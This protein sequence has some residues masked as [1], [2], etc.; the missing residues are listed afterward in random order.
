MA[1][2]LL[3][4]YM[5]CIGI[6][7]IEIAR[8]ETAI[9]RWGGHFLKHVYTQRELGLCRNRTPHLAAQFAAKEAVMKALGTGSPHIGW[10]EIEILSSSNGKPQ[11]HLGG[12]AEIKAQELGLEEIVI[13]LSH[14]RDYAIASV[15]GFATTPSEAE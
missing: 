8:I 3:N 12:R 11:V 14:S 10:Q 9:T 1:E 15:V 7:V 5:H 2:C 4:A 13:S 6:D